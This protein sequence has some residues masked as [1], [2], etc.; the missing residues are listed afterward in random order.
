MVRDPS[1]PRRNEFVRTNFRPCSFSAR[2]RFHHRRLP[3]PAKMMDAARASV[4][5]SR[6]VLDVLRRRVRMRVVYFSIK[7][8]MASSAAECRIVDCTAIVQAQLPLQG[9]WTWY[10]FPDPRGAQSALL[11]HQSGG[12]EAANSNYRGGLVGNLVGKRRIGSWDDV[13]R[14]FLGIWTTN[15]PFFAWIVSISRR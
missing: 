4:P 10:V 9:S 3:S 11:F 2:L 8:A 5:R 14:F 1:L 7:A 12:C 15:W 13:V 6:V